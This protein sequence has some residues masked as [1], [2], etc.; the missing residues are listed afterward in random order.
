MPVACS[1]GGTLHYRDGRSHR[2]SVSDHRVGLVWRARSTRI[3]TRRAGVQHGEVS[4]PLHAAH[5]RL[6][7]GELLR[8]LHPRTWLFHQ[9]FY[10]RRNNK[11]SEPDW[12]RWL[13]FDA[14]RDP[15]GIRQDRAVD[16][17]QH[18]ES[19]L[20]HRVLCGPIPISHAG[21]YRLRNSGLRRNC[22]N[23]HRITRP[24]LHTIPC[25]R[26][27]RLVVLGMAQ[28]VSRIQLLQSRRRS[29]DECSV[30]CS[31]ELLH[32]TWPERVGPFLDGPDVAA[33]R[34]SRTG[35]HL[36]PLQ[37]SD[38]DSQPIHRQYWWTRWWGPGAWR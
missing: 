27:T 20:R 32:P 21:R 11:S 31:N 8:H 6:R 29:H 34:H 12:R 15:H 38:H 33:S 37:D 36:H 24:D 30:P 28:S 4:E 17:E 1:H 9:G 13:D 5:L 16:I 26:Q 14:E 35:Q 25:R 19:V 22:R 10:R 23:D 2:H 7:D 3:G 18:D